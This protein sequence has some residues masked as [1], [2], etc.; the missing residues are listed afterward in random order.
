MN[1][2]TRK[3]GTINYLKR[4]LEKDYISEEEFQKQKKQIE[5]LSFMQIMSQAKPSRANKAKRSLGRKQ[6]LLHNVGLDEGDTK[7]KR[8]FEL[9]KKLYQMLI[10]KI[11]NIY[12][13][14]Y[15]LFFVEQLNF[16]YY[17]F[18]YDHDY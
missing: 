7:A 2:F 9:I 5:K 4:L 14:F 3:I 10:N 18:Y 8:L 13:P 11:K 1:P 12:Y 15:L 16:C 6:A 17:D